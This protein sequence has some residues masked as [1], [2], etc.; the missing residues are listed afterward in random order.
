[1]KSPFG[2]AS[3]LLAAAVVLVVV[4]AL[5]AA[6][7]AALTALGVPRAE[8]LAADPEA[9]LRARSLGR[10]VSRPESAAAAM[11]L[12]VALTSLSA[13]ALFATAAAQLPA[14]AN[15]LAM[16]GAVLLGA[17]LTV[18][19]ASAGRRVGATHPQRVA[20]ALAPP[21]RALTVVLA[22]VARLVGLA[23]T[24]LVG[25]PGRFTL[26][27]PPIE[28]V[29]R[30][31]AAHARSRD[32]ADHTS[33]LIHR[34]LEFREK[35]ARDIMVPRTDVMAID[36]EMP[37]PEIIQRLAEEGHSRVPVFE[38]SLD[39]VVGILHARDL[40]PLLAHPEL[41]VL[42]DLLRPPT[43]APWSTPV[44]VLLRSMQRKH[45]HMMIV[46]DE[47]GG[48][49]GAVTLEDV[50]EEIVGEIR[51][52][53]D[54]DEGGAVEP[55]PDG[56]FAVRGDAGIPEF[57][58]ATGAGL[59]EGDGWETVAGFVVAQAGAIPARGDR[60]AWRDWKFTVSETDGRRLTRLRV[61]RERR[62]PA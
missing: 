50:L 31:L 33:E 20:L 57:N 39:K 23:V 46:V 14:G 55:L 53:W 6:F 35:V 21:V 44:Q 24:P 3:E 61:V 43:F 59:P 4:R 40:V 62:P 42:R 58:E 5:C 12:L 28:E 1:M 17:L 54:A 34:V 32:P 2:P 56:G 22:P 11:R 36:V 26:P 47:Y 30:A 13:G 41:I 7:E 8:A 48:V 25:G 49:M 18:A 37:V 38:G 19:L 10:V 27:L 51:D 16:A 15:A 60:V 52:E 29:E 45:Q 9:G